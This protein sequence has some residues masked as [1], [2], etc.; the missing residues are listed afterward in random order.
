MGGNLSYADRSCIEHVNVFHVRSRCISFRVNPIN[1]AW[2]YNTMCRTSI[3]STLNK[4]LDVEGGS[5]ID[6]RRI[7]VRHGAIGEVLVS[8]SS[9]L[10]TCVSFSTSCPPCNM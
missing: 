9:S 6:K 1:P 7:I 2:K 5:S 3:I 8:W 10:G 4:A